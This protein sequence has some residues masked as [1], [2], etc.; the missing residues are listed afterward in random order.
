MKFLKHSVPYI[1]VRRTTIATAMTASTVATARCTIHASRLRARTTDIVATCPTRSTR[2][3]VD[4]AFTAS[5]VSCTTR[6]LTHHAYM[7]ACATLSTD[8]SSATAN[9][10]IT[11]H[12]QFLSTDAYRLHIYVVD[13]VK[14]YSHRWRFRYFFLTYCHLPFNTS[15]LCFSNP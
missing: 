7:A 2:A 9:L 5:I 15:R 10:D 4:R 3:A 13:A 1:Q 14:K 6:A 11:G 12:L 8:S